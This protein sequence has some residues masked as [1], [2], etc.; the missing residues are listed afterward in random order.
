MASKLDGGEQA[1]RTRA[2]YQY[3][4]RA[5]AHPAIEARSLQVTPS[6]VAFLSVG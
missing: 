1:R 3:L 6:F 5:R 2:D 4:D